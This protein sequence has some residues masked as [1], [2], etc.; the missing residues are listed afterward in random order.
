MKFRRRGQ[1]GKSSKIKCLLFITRLR[2]L[3][4][5]NMRETSAAT[6]FLI[7][8]CHNFIYHLNRIELW[9][10]LLFLWDDTMMFENMKR[11]SWP[12]IVGWKII[13]L[14][15]FHPRYISSYCN[16]FLVKTC[17]EL[18]LFWAFKKAC[19]IL[20]MLGISLPSR[21]SPIRLLH[22]LTGLWWVY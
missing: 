8:L 3:S 1:K 4:H 18:K 20:R 7:F 13:D 22:H 11:S 21:G 5:F 17:T 16:K 2:V 19:M 6:T 15:I 10:L 12:F 9:Y 14:K